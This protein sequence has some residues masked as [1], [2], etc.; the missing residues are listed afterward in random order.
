MN[1]NTPNDYIHPKQTDTQA[2][3]TFHDE[4]KKIVPALIKEMAARRKVLVQFIG[5]SIALINAESDDQTYRYFWKL[6]LSLNEGEELQEV[7]R[8]LARLHRLQNMIDGK[9]AP[10]GMLPNDLIEVA[11]A[12]P[13]T[14]IVG[15]PVR[16]SGK[17]YLCVCPLHEDHDPSMRVYAEQNRAWCFVCNDGG[18]SIGLYMAI[19]G[20]DF[21]TAVTELAGGKA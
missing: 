20:C 3:A 14:D 21:K 5:D 11:R 13:I 9:P 15:E 10:K 1:K 7:D 17:D 16:R 8:E 12:V 6:W 4:A 18:D 2:L 19:N